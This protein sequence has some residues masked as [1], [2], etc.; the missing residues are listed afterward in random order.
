[1]PLPLLPC[2]PLLVELLP[3][4]PLPPGPDDVPFFGPGLDL[5]LEV[6]FPFCGPSAVPCACPELRTLPV[7]PPV[8]G[9]SVVRCQG[10]GGPGRVGRE[11]G[12]DDE[13]LACCAVSSWWKGNFGSSSA[14]NAQASSRP[15]RLSPQRATR[16][17][18]T[19][20][21]RSARW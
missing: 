7:P 4:V 1:M 9:V 6:L 3:V 14:S 10:S 5:L 21:R 17:V 8:P 15:S 19:V 11:L 18:E 20:R 16:A 12:D 2:P 13:E